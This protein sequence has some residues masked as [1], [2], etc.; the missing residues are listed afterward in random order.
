MQRRVGQDEELKEAGQKAGGEEEGAGE[1]VTEQQPG[2]G[3]GSL[4]SPYVMVTPAPPEEP[5]RRPAPANLV[6]SWGPRASK[7]LKQSSTGGSS[8]SGQQLPVR[9]SS[10]RLG[11]QLPPKSSYVKQHQASLSVQAGSSR[12]MTPRRA[13]LKAKVEAAVANA[14]NSPRLAKMAPKRPRWPQ[15]G[16]QDTPKGPRMAPR[17]PQK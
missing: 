10:P 17:C 11:P 3:A 6:T 15:D 1:K 7:T 2:E 8:K 5:K 14:R 12:P 4:G 16:S 13:A 9:R